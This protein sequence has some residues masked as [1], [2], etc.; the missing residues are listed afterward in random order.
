[1]GK[2]KVDDSEGWN[3]VVWTRPGLFSRYKWDDRRA[4]RLVWWRW[5][6]TVR[7]GRTSWIIDVSRKPPWEVE[8]HRWP[9]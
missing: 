7:L 3:Y 5:G 4:Y 9:R 6:V 2:M 8:M 1:M